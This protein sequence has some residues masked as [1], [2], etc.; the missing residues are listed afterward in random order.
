MLCKNFVSFFSFSWIRAQDHKEE[1]V[2]KILIFCLSVCFRATVFTFSILGNVLISN[3]SNFRGFPF[4]N[5]GRASCHTDLH[6]ITETASKYT[7]PQIER[8]DLSV[9]VY[10]VIIFLTFPNFVHFSAFE[11]LVDSQ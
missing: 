5:E 2:A 10:T 11:T 6:V 8:T 9:W 1:D 3:R 4:E 7:L